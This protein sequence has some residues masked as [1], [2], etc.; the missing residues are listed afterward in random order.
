[1]TRLEGTKWL[2]VSLL[3]GSDLQL[4]EC[5]RLRVKDLDL[6]YNQIVVRDAK[7]QKDRA[8][9]SPISLKDPLMKMT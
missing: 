6:E 2:M 1:M 4:M 8:T 9:M 3:Y 5:V 7:G